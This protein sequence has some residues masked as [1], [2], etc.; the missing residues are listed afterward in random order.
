MLPLATETDRATE[1]SIRGIGV[2]L[3]GAASG[4]R[5]DTSGLGFGVLGEGRLEM[6]F[7]EREEER[8]AGGRRDWRLVLIRRVGGVVLGGFRGLLGGCGVSVLVGF[9]GLDCSS[10]GPSSFRSM[11]V[12]EQSE[13]G[14]RDA[15]ETMGLGHGALS[16]A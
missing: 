1:T 13:G 9:V 15:G 3:F 14:L 8:G 10:G 2:W 11:V 6:V 4:V 12:D 5:G 7:G 16:D